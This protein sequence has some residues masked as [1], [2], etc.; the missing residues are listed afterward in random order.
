MNVISTIG[1]R[2]C[3]T[4]NIDE[5]ITS[6]SDSI[7]IN[8]SHGNYDNIKY[9]VSYIRKNYKNVKIIMDLQ[10]NKIRVSSNIKDTFK[11]IRDEIVYFCGEDNYEKIL[12]EKKESK[13]I[14]LNIKSHL[15]L[16]NTGYKKIYMKDGTMEFD[17]KEVTNNYIQTIV[18][19]G[20]IVRGEKGCNLP[21]IKRDEWKISEKDIRDIKF[22]LDND[23]DIICYSYCSYEKQCKEFKNIVFKNIKN[24]GKVPKVW[25]KIET[26]EGIENIKC[27]AKELDGIVIA[28]GDLVPEAGLFNIP[29]IQEKIIYSL[30]NTN[31]E[32]IVAT[33]LLSS[34]KYFTK[35]T[36]S[37]L[38]VIYNLLKVGVTGFMLTG[39]T[40]IGK[41]TTEVIKTLNLAIKYYGNIL[42]KGRKRL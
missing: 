41:N 28:R 27:I 17:V 6:G 31:K 32:I 14:P 18:R 40:T 42:D 24:L 26:K 11:V 13:V 38:S 37:E 25:G 23:V 5:I 34:M 39:E 21:G 9:I 10:G 20:G 8:L 15:I 2:N 16:E 1:P 3:R 35:P 33:N 30:K 7:R 19:L 12:K 4:F 29:I 36:I 22:A